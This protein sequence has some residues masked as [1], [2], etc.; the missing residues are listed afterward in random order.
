M[1][2]ALTFNP[3]ESIEHNLQ[4]MNAA[5]QGL[6]T[7]EVT[8][9]VRDSDLDGISV[10]AGQFIGLV[11][12]KMVAAGQ[13]AEAVLLEALATQSPT[14]AR[15][16]TLYWGMDSSQEKCDE[17]AAEIEREVPGIQVD[18]IFGGQP[19]YPYLASVD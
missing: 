10:E 14:D 18:S 3:E 5:I 19:H 13:T 9:A 7:I 2:A 1:A 11:D 17:A 6:V 15:T 12:G 4:A 8:Q 16:V